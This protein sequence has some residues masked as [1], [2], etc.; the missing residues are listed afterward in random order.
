MDKCWLP[1]GGSV[2][3]G[4]NGILITG[5]I[6]YQL[7]NG[8]NVCGNFVSMV[9]FQDNERGRPEAAFYEV[10]LDTLELTNALGNLANKK[11]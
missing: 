10:N 2:Q 11:R 7:K 6:W 4:R 8:P 3:A 1:Y 5:S 9:V